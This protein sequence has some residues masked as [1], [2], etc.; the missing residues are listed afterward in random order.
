MTSVTVVFSLLCSFI[1]H[2]SSFIVQT[3]WGKKTSASRCSISSA[4]SRFAAGTSFLK[5][6]C[7]ISRNPK[8]SMAGDVQHGLG[9]RRSGAASLLPARGRVELGVEQRHAKRCV[10]HTPS[11][12]GCSSCCPSAWLLRFAFCWCLVGSV[13]HCAGIVKPV[14]NFF[15]AIVR[16]F[17]PSFTHRHTHTHIQTACEFAAVWPRPELVQAPLFAANRH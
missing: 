16:D 2:R 12:E 14:D 8:F 7:E 11:T 15:D 17:S 13:L 6:L 5:F 1:V 3:S 9:G 4:T 10:R